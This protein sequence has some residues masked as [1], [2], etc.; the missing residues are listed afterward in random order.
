[1]EVGR[2]RPEVLQALTRTPVVKKQ[3]RLV[4]GEIR[5]EARILAQGSRDSGNLI[6]S[7]AVDNV[8]NDEGLVE[9]R[10]GWAK[11]GFYGSLVELGTVD[12]P[13]QPH[14][15]PSAIKVAGRAG[16]RAVTH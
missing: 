1:M 8:L 9:F 14:L 11:R 10:V 6:R 16:R 4:A 15:R 12:T 2:L 7:I 5:K 3:M 13:A